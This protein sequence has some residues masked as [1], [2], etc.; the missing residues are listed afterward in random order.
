MRLAL[1]V[2]CFHDAH[3]SSKAPGILPE[4]I[5]RKFGRLRMRQRLALTECS[6]LVYEILG[7]VSDSSVCRVPCGSINRQIGYDCTVAM[8]DAVDEITHSSIPPAFDEDGI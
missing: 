3:Q 4:E 8:I 5:E 1:N 6:D 7:C 2:P